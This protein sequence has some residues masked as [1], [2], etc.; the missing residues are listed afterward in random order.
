M[1]RPKAA[2]SEPQQERYNRTVEQ[3]PT[4]PRK[5]RPLRWVLCSLAGLAAMLLLCYGLLA[6]AFYSNPPRLTRNFAAELNEPILA[7]PPAERAWPKYRKVLKDF[8]EL[9]EPSPDFW[10]SEEYIQSDYPAEAERAW[11]EL[12]RHVVPKI[13]AASKF[14]RLGFIVRDGTDAD[15]LPRRPKRHGDAWIRAEQPQP[16]DHE[17]AS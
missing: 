16:P 5:Q 12:N 4:K 10:V 11:R 3:K 6:Y 17:R 13:R 2:R 7:I 15:E 14:P 1:Q 9:E 8:R